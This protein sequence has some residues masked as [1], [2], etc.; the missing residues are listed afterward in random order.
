MYLKINVLDIEYTGINRIRPFRDKDFH[1]VLVR[2]HANAYTRYNDIKV[3]ND[4]RGLT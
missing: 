3:S 4:N 2:Q 1:Y